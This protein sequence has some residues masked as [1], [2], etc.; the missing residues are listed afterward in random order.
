[1][2]SCCSPTRPNLPF[3][4]SP[5]K[6]ARARTQTCGVPVSVAHLSRTRIAILPLVTSSGAA[7]LECQVISYLA[8]APGSLR[9]FL[10]ELNPAVLAWTP[11]QDPNLPAGSC[12]LNS[13]FPDSPA[14][15]EPSPPATPEPSPPH[16]HR[17]LS[18][19]KQSH[20]RQAAARCLICGQRS[21]WEHHL[22]RAEPALRPI[23]SGAPQWP[24]IPHRSG[25]PPWDRATRSGKPLIRPCRW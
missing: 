23:G 19:M 11:H 22:G 12:P 1:L 8:N 17:A 20:H 25:T 13:R 16:C 3:F 9:I 15:P 14:T 5:A 4:F 2:A 6:N 21:A 24:R 7:L 10:A 18:P